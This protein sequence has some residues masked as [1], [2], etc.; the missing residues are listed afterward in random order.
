MVERYLDQA[1]QLY[2]TLP[3][4]EGPAG[5]VRIS[6][7][8]AQLAEAQRGGDEPE[9]PEEKEDAPISVKP[10]HVNTEPLQVFQKP[11]GAGDPVRELQPFTTVTL[12][13]SQQ[14]DWVL[15]AKEGTSLGYVNRTRLHELV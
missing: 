9:E 14:Q 8:R 7:L 15:I 3:P 11:D 4:P 13:T 10:T 2:L 5:T 1:E 12:L 6:E